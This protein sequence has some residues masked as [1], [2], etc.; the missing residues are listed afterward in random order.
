MEKASWIIRA[1]EI[2]VAEGVVDARL[3]EIVESDFETPEGDHFVDIERLKSIYGRRIKFFPEGSYEYVEIERLLHA[4]DATPS[5]ELKMIPISQSGKTKTF[6]LVNK[7][8]D[9]IAYWSP[10]WEF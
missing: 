10:L 7:N 4:L 8:R 1:V 5:V 6:I 9:R 3:M 2:A